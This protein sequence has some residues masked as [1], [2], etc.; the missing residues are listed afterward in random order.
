MLTLIEW[1]ISITWKI[2]CLSFVLGVF[3]ALL[4]NGRGTIKQMIETCA[5]ALKVGLDRLQSWLFS[6]YKGS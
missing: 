5:M 1:C 2:L 3:G 6:K 4:R